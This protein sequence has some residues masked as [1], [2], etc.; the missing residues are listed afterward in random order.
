VATA[1]DMPGFCDEKN[2][3]RTVR[4]ILTCISLMEKD[5]GS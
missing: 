2:V 4:S 1:E 3:W 5:Y